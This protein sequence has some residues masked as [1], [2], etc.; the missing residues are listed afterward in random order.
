[1]REFWTISRAS[2]SAVKS[3]APST[4][5][6]QSKKNEC[7]SSK[8]SCLTLTLPQRCK[9]SR[10]TSSSS[11]SPMTPSRRRSSYSLSSR[12]SQPTMCGRNHPEWAWSALRWSRWPGRK[13]TSQSRACPQLIREDQPYQFIKF[14]RAWTIR[15]IM[16]MLELG[17]IR[18]WVR[19]YFRSSKD[20]S[21]VRGWLRASDTWELLHHKNSPIIHRTQKSTTARRIQ[22]TSYKSCLSNSST[23]I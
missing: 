8:L 20:A 17:T 12:R 16:G 3:R 2:P 22:K 9:K 10:P 23:E 18:R 11:S 13:S 15:S 1:M 5:G 4:I 6:W 14:K 21:R 7:R 19:D